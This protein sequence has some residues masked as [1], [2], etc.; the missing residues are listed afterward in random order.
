M[1]KRGAERRLLKRG[2]GNSFLI[3]LPLLFL[4]LAS[5]VLAVVSSQILNVGFSISPATVK[6]GEF[7]QPNFTAI[8]NGPNL[9]INIPINYS[10]SGIV[11]ITQ[12]LP[13]NWTNAVVWKV[14]EGNVIKNITITDNIMSW[15]ANLSA[16]SAQLFFEISP[17]SMTAQANFT[18]QTFF[19]KNITIET[20]LD[21]NH[22]R[23]V[24]TNV[25][26]NSSFP[27]Y[28]LYWLVND[29]WEDYTVPFNLKVE[30]GY[31]F[32]YGFNTSSQQFRIQGFGSC[33]ESW[34]CTGWSDSSNS[35]GTRTC[36]DNAHC[37]TTANKPSESATCPSAGSG[38]SGGGGGGG[39]G[40]RRAVIPAPEPEKPNPDFSVDNNLIKV[41]LRQDV[42]DRKALKIANTGNTNLTIKVEIIG[43]EN[44][45]FLQAGEA[46]YS[47]KLDKGDSKTININF[48]A[49]K[50]KE[51]GSYTGKIR[52]NA[53]GIEKVVGIII[54]VESEKPIF[55]VAVT[56]PGVYRQVLPGREV[57]AQINIFNLKTVGRV[58]VSVDY[59]IKDFSGNLLA[60]G[61]FT[62]AV[63]TSASFVKGLS[64]P[65][66][67][68]AGQYV[69]FATVRYRNIVTSGSDSFEVIER[70]KA[71]FGLNTF[72]I[73]AAF[74]SFVFIVF[75]LL[76]FIAVLD[77]LHH[78]AAGKGKK[79]EKKK[80]EEEVYEEEEITAKEKSEEKEGAEEIQKKLAALEEAFESG[81]ISARAY[82]EDKAKLERIL[83]KRQK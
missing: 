56:I 57:V 68:T 32:F 72:V 44:F 60:S 65:Q 67:T 40:G 47:F 75:M 2:A 36:T 18:N 78:P 50:L 34:T 45:A 7:S 83:K 63:E 33:T 48:L 59:G 43:L 52:V 39:G 71:E 66:N 13:A 1:L 26:V 58:D 76:I 49:P 53:E 62:A 12:N 8:V 11:N 16:V 31:A 28:T 4:I 80:E 20:V 35:C 14:R 3:L 51:P 46:D 64:I 19:E 77:M 22:F 42:P 25:S 81:L 79:I 41:L 29:T 37:G 17:P 82:I 23:N 69:M 10:G 6:S 55:D 61:D 70:P 30:N 38:S 24:S 15:E 27:Y 73:V 74:A 21:G 9:T 5:Y 54:E